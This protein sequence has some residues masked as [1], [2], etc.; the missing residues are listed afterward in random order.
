MQPMERN[1]GSGK[2]ADSVSGE[3]MYKMSL[4]HFVTLGHKKLSK[5]TEVISEGL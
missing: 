5:S 1:Q 3:E 2:V 4:E